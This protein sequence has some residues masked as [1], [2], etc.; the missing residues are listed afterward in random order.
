[1][2]KEIDGLN[3]PSQSRDLQKHLA[4]NSEAKKLFEEL[5]RTAETLQ[6]VGLKEPPSYL[7]SHILNSIKFAPPDRASETGWIGQLVET[8]Q[9][10]SFRRYSVVFVSGLCIGLGI[11][12]L[13]NPWREDG[14]DTSKVSGSM[15]LF[16]ELPSLQIVDS[17]AIEGDGVDGAFRTYR[18]KGRIVV[19][20]EVKS[21][22]QVRV[23]LNSDP[24][25]LVFGGIGR[26][27]G[28]EGDINVTQGKTI[29]T[30]MNSDRSIVSF[31]EV[32]L[33]QRPIEARI[34]RG[35]S[36]LQSVMLRTR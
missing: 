4:S 24:A 13:T 7:R 34:Y 2:N 12:F 32:G 14:T 23:E 25:E 9:T 26:L 20:I 1:M 16:P 21:P 18:G 31:T 30:V 11:F 15:V 3:T 17:I 19:E 6:G 27:A 29:F 36:I 8:F 5:Q 22:A 35:G 10:R 33:A 28:T